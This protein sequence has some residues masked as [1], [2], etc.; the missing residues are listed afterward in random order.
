M[1]NT[2]ELLYHRL[3]NLTNLDLRLALY[4]F[5]L[6]YFETSKADTGDFT[7]RSYGYSRDHRA[8]VPRS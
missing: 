2:E 5:T 8:T 6:T 4:D 3:T 7:S 1:E